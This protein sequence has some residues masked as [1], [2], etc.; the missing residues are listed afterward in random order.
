MSCFDLVKTGQSMSTHTCLVWQ[1]ILINIILPWC[2]SVFVLE[3]Q[4]VASPLQN[5]CQSNVQ[6][7]YYNAF[8]GHALN[9]EAS[10]SRETRAQVTV[11]WSYN[12]WHCIRKEPW[13]ICTMWTT[14]SM[15]LELTKLALLRCMCGAVA[16]HLTFI[17]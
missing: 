16:S 7:F 4:K 9:S 5:Q 10:N 17:H 8:E 1:S 15:Q 3:F 13:Y 12:T 14:R 11:K 2:E 6:I